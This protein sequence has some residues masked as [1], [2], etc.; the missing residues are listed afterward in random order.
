LS[1]VV[2]SQDALGSPKQTIRSPVISRHV[3]Q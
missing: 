2:F 1:F 3:T